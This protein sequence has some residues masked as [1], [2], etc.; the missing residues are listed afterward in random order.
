MNIENITE[1]NN[2]LETFKTFKTDMKAAMQEKIMKEVGNDITTYPQKVRELETGGAG[3]LEITGTANYLFTHP[4]Q[5]KISYD[6]HDATLYRLVHYLTSLPSEDVEIKPI[7]IDFN[8]G[9]KIST[10]SSP[11]PFNV[12][13]STAKGVFNTQGIKRF[14]TIRNLP[15]SSL[16]SVFYGV[17]INN[18][19]IKV[20]FDDE[21][22]AGKTFNLRGAFSSIAGQV[23]E[24]P[25]FL[26]TLI[27]LANEL[28]EF[29]DSKTF[30]LEGQEITFELAKTKDL[31]IGHN[32]VCFNNFICD[33][34]NLYM[35]NNFSRY[36]VSSG[37]FGGTS[38]IKNLNLIGT[39]FF[40]PTQNNVVLVSANSSIE[41][42]KVRLKT[43]NS[44]SC[45][46]V[47]NSVEIL[48]GSDFAAISNL[49]YTTQEGWVEFFESLPGVPEGSTY[50]NKINIAADYYALL[51]EEDMMIAMNKGY[52]LASV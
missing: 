15:T 4:E 27:P 10:L 47:T 33:T 9:N 20:E 25:E 42:L 21:Y 18:G 45:I 14:F 50:A 30:N 51:S 29:N 32:Y 22:L 8:K 12:D 34:L 24:V 37:I 44:L 19:K 31:S 52:T 7:I 3:E 16:G 46:R 39:G 40:N 1:L 35:H 48:E 11:Y 38:K 41:N 17:D 6:I 49:P 36:G 2:I 28:R 5:F 23:T 43:A 26:Y 13:N